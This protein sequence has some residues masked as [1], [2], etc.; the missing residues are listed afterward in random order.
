MLRLIQSTKRPIRA[1]ASAILFVSWSAAGADKLD[2][3]KLLKSK[4]KKRLRTW[5]TFPQFLV[6]AGI[7]KKEIDLVGFQA[8][9]FW[10]LKFSD[11]SRGFGK[12]LTNSRLIGPPLSS[13]IYQNSIES[14]SS[15]WG[16]SAITLEAFIQI[17]TTKLPMTTVAKKNGMHDTSPT[18]IQSHID[19]IHSPHNT[20]NT[21]MNECIKSVKFHRGISP[22]GNKN[23]R[24]ENMTTD[25]IRFILYCAF[26][27][28]T[29][30]KHATFY[31]HDDGSFGTTRINAFAWI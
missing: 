31:T 14:I 17:L 9:S 12:I 2:E 6:F 23:T 1:N 30:N 15:Q 21:I 11:F 7:Q 20:R 13:G 19:S 26:W 28:S 25:L 27:A 24:S 16:R 8:F 10:I 5:F 18:S 3:P 4:A 29:H 22:S